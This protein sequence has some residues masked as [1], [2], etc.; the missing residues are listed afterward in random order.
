MPSI[1]SHFVC[2][3][4]VSDKLDVDVEEFY[5]GNILPDIALLND[6][7]NKV[8]GSFYLIPNIEYFVE[9]SDLNEDIELGYLCHL[10]LDKYFF[11]LL[12]VMLF[13]DLKK[14]IKSLAKLLIKFILFS[15]IIYHPLQL[16]KHNKFIM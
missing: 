2:A 5:K 7:H 14:Y 16:L 9:N 15:Y 6:S 3:K 4:L 8:R 12:R 13:S 11:N 10:L 1:A